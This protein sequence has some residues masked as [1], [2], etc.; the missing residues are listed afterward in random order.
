MGEREGQIGSRLHEAG[1]QRAARLQQAAAEAAQ[2]AEQ[3]AAA[4][5][6]EA[7]PEINSVS[8][9]CVRT[10]PTPPFTAPVVARHAF[11]HALCNDGTRSLQLDR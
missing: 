6:K 8:A 3:R 11:T 10:R 5:A 7:I 4:E 2:K 9:M 1:R